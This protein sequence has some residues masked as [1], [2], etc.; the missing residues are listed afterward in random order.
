MPAR[1]RTDRS[2]DSLP[3]RREA[4][5]H[6]GP[7]MENESGQSFGVSSSMDVTLRGLHLYTVTSIRKAGGKTTRRELQHRIA[8]RGRKCR[9]GILLVDFGAAVA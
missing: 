5:N 1:V 8:V 3:K 2:S 6:D 7:C 4:R 9:P